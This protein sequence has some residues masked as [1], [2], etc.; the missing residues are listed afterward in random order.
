MAMRDNNATVV[1]PGRYFTDGTRLFRLLTPP[2]SPIG[3]GFVEL[4]DCGSLDVLLVSAERLQRLRRVRP[5]ADAAATRA[6]WE[7]GARRER[8]ATDA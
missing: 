8:V 5:S 1:R 7:Q 2:G 3:G 4:E 6:R